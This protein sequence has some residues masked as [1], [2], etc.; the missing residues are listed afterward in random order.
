[1]HAEQ[2]FSGRFHGSSKQMVALIQHGPVA[3]WRAPGSLPVDQTAIE[4]LA[5]VPGTRGEVSAGRD[6]DPQDR[7]SSFATARLTTCDAPAGVARLQ[8]DTVAGC[9]RNPLA[10]GGGQWQLRACPARFCGVP[11][12]TVNAPGM[13]I[14]PIVAWK[15][16]KNLLDATIDPHLTERCRSANSPDPE[17]IGTGHWSLLPHARHAND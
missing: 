2:T 13:P 3:V 7:S 8:G 5:G 16:D 10:A 12:V 11:V 17:T 1:M 4:G 14:Y 6:C 15:H 9:E